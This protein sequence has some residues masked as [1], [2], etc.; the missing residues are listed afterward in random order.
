MF[1]LSIGSLAS[2]FEELQASLGLC[3]FPFDIIGISETKHIDGHTL[4]TNVSLEG[5]SLHS[6]SSKSSYGGLA[7]FVN[8]KLEHFCRNDLGLSKKNY[9]KPYGWRSNKR[10][11][12]SVAVHTDILTQMWMNLRIT[13]KKSFK[14]I[15]RKIN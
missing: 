2:N 1:H 10:K 14:K 4:T 15:L 8:E 6:Q 7:L 12:F 9:L 3:G 11:I 5:Y 13:L